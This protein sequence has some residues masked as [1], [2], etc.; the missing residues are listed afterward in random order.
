MDT[1]KCPKCGQNTDGWKCAICGSVSGQHDEAHV[2]EGSDRYCMPRC[3]PCGQAVV[4]CT[5][6]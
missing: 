4:H 1:M 3:G 5:C 2:H 6:S